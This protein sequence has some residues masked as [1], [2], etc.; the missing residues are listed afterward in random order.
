MSAQHLTILTGASRGMGLAMAQQLIEAG[1]AL[2]CISRKTDEALAAQAAAK[3]VACEL[4]PKDLG[5]AETAAARL[6]GWLAACDSAGL[7]S[8]TLINNAAVVPRIAPIGD[9]PAAELAESMR[10]DLE[11]PMLLTAAFLKAT[12]G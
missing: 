5:R 1:H 2:V 10:V 9:I 7:V 8:V 4:G 11:A 12:A 3:G 6:E